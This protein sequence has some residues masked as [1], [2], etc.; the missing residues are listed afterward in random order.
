MLF[1]LLESCFPVVNL[2][3]NSINK[4]GERYQKYSKFEAR[5]LMNELARMKYDSAGGVKDFIIKMVHIQT[6]LAS[7]EIIIFEKFIVHH[8]F[9]SLPLEFSNIQT[10]Y[11]AMNE[12][13]SVNDLISKCVFEEKKL[14]KEKS[15]SAL[16]AT[17]S[18]HNFWKSFKKP[19]KNPLRSIVDGIIGTCNYGL[20]S[21]Q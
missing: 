10:T 9:N 7:H 11:N 15:E 1:G 18:K 4:H 19:G 6:K 3:H 2:G 12:N 20:V 14:K 16:L 21:C 13:W 17:H 8:A 5:N